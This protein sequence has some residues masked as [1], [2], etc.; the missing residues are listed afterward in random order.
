MLKHTILYSN[1]LYFCDIYLKTEKILSSD[2]VDIYVNTFF[3]GINLFQES[4]LPW[5]D[6]SSVSEPERMFL[7]KTQPRAAVAYDQEVV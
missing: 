7:R 5:S 1:L 2:K 6:A 4:K 3:K